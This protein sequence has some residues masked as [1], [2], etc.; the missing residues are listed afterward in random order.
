MKV[1]IHLCLGFTKKWS[2][3][4]G[5]EKDA[6][7]KVKDQIRKVLRPPADGSGRIGIAFDIPDPM[8]SVIVLLA[9]LQDR[10]SLDM[11]PDK[12]F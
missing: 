9:E 8:V 3:S 12:L 4:K 7:E 2:I 11:V 10:Q 6:Y 1:V 5:E